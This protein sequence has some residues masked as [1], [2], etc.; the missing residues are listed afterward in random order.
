VPLA[1]EYNV[2]TSFIRTRFTVPWARPFTSAAPANAIAVIGTSDVMFKQKSVFDSARFNAVAP[3]W[4]QYAVTGM[5]IEYFPQPYIGVSQ[6]ISQPLV[7]KISVNGGLNKLG[8]NGIKV[9]TQ[10]LITDAGYRQ[11][12]TNRKFTKYINFKPLSRA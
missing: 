3:N 7:T 12:A 9:P 1:P 4:K 5:R 6:A 8:D 11:I 2:G 10:D